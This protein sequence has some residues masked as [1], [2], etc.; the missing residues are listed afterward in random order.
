MTFDALHDRASARK[1]V[2]SAPVKMP[3]SED[4]DHSPLTGRPR[5]DPGRESG[6][7]CIFPGRNLRQME[8]GS[9]IR[10]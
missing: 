7:S 2:N 5:R 9:D 6:S 10:H 8:S 3:E 1:R 4:L